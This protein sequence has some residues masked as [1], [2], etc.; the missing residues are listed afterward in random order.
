MRLNSNLVTDLLYS[1]LDASKK[2]SRLPISKE[3]FQKLMAT[4]DV[5]NNLPWDADRLKDRSL[6][7]WL[8]PKAFQNF[9]L[10]SRVGVD[11]STQS[12]DLRAREKVDEDAMSYE[13]F[14]NSIDKI[15]GMM[16][17]QYNDEADIQSLRKAVT[18]SDILSRSMVDGNVHYD[19]TNPFVP[20]T[21][22]MKL[23]KD[24]Y[25]NTSFEDEIADYS[26]EWVKLF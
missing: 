8:I 5:I 23:M 13:E 12:L 1:K 15:Y 26:R 21:L 16:K 19:G 9:I 7:R 24:W 11:I 2:V 3:E 10:P 20:V 25:Y 22:S 17:A 18:I 6:N 4:F 14:R